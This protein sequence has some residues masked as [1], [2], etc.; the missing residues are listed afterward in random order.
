ML[1]RLAERQDL[2]NTSQHQ[3]IRRVFGVGLTLNSA[4]MLVDDPVA[5]GRLEAAI[6]E[7]DETIRE[8]RTSLF[9]SGPATL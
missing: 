6:N 7:L 2:A 9:G 5:R 4:L 1:Q 3:V 8:I